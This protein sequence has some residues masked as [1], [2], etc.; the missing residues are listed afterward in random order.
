MSVNRLRVW[1]VKKQKARRC[2]REGHN[3]YAY[4]DTCRR[5]GVNRHQEVQP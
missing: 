2:G 4:R 5:C 1:W 3:F